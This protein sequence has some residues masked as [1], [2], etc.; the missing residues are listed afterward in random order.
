MIRV[1]HSGLAWTSGLDRQSP[2][3]FSCVLNCPRED[4]SP[5]CAGFAQIAQVGNEVEPQPVQNETALEN[6]PAHA[7]AEGFVRRPMYDRG[8]Q[9]P[10]DERLLDGAPGA[11]SE[12]FDFLLQQQ[13]ELIARLTHD[14]GTCSVAIDPGAHRK[15]Q[16]ICCPA[17]ELLRCKWPHGSLREQRHQAERK[18]GPETAFAPLPY[19]LPKSGIAVTGEYVTT[20]FQQVSGTVKLAAYVLVEVKT[21]ADEQIRRSQHGHG[22]PIEAYRI[23]LGEDR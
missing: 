5:P 21:L 19:L 13:V 17:G 16:A 18:G 23:E 4:N 3:A 15:G 9:P 10:R 14:G 1:H 2:I 11:D 22:H 20:E 8:R 6:V 12:C 7:G